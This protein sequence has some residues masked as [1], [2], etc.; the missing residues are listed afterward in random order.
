MVQ[1]S[2]LVSRNGLLVR[3]KELQ[4]RYG[5]PEYE[6]LDCEL[7]DGPPNGADVFHRTSKIV[8]KA[9]ADASTVRMNIIDQY[10]DGSVSLKDLQARVKLLRSDDYIR[11]ATCVIPQTLIKTVAQLKA[12]EAKCLAQGYEGTMLRRADQGTYP[13]KTKKDGKPCKD[14]RSTLSEFYLARLKRF[15]YDEAKIIAVKPLVHNLNEDRTARGARSSKK[16]GMVVDKTRIGS[17]TLRYVKTGKEF[18]TNIATELL[19]TKPAAWWARQIG[20]VVRYKY[21]K[22]GTIDKPR[23]NTCGFEELTP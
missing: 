5:R 11:H 10:D 4:A 21:Q 8:T 13:Q 1:R 22:V 16:A 3:N 18:D 23:I 15:E 19:R 12:Y 2:K 20:K 9:N 17:A 14:N 7:T 6:S